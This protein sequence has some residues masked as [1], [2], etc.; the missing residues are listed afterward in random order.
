MKPARGSKLNHVPAEERA[1]TL[2]YVREEPLW[3]LLQVRWRLR[4]ASVVQ[5]FQLTRAAVA[6]IRAGRERAQ[7]KMKK[8]LKQAATRKAAK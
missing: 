1:L 2:W 4:R 8:F 3:R 5:K 7:A 6:R